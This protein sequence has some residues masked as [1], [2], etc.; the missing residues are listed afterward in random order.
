[1]ADDFRREGLGDAP[2]VRHEHNRLASVRQRRLVI[3][4][5]VIAAGVIAREGLGKRSLGVK[6]SIQRSE[7]EL[8]NVVAAM[9]DPGLSRAG[10]RASLN[11]LWDFWPRF[12]LSWQKSWHD[13][14]YEMHRSSFGV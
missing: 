8:H 2:T 14:I 7:E 13:A 11:P 4:A 6:L 9:V 12:T 10:H 1:M 5:G 3:A